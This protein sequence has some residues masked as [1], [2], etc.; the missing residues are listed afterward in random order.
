MDFIR[1]FIDLIG[2]SGA[3]LV[4]GAY[5]LNSFG[6]L[7][8]TDLRYQLMNLA[9]GLFFIVNTAFLKAYPSMVVNIIWVLI[10]LMALL[11]KK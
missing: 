7:S 1:L 8:A 9:G 2:W 6:R 4:V 3:V 11:R 10:A 5:L